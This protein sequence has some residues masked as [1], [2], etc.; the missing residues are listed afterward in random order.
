MRKLDSLEAASKNEGGAAGVFLGAGAG[1]ALSPELRQP[2]QESEV[3][4]SASQRLQHLKNLFTDELITEE[5][6]A[7]KKQS[8]LDEI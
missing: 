8:I 3:K 5:E 7:Q 1:E 4:Q 6:Y 2:F